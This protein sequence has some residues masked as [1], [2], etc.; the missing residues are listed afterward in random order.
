MRTGRFAAR[1]S[2]SRFTVPNFWADPKTGI[3]YQVQVEIPRP[4]VRNVDGIDT[5]HSAEDLGQIPLKRE[6]DQ[7][8]LVTFLKPLDAENSEFAPTRSAISLVKRRARP[9]TRLILVPPFSTHAEIAATP[10]AVGLNIAFGT[11]R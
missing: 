7:Q 8:V 3:A 4:V 10:A 5:I 1:T 9:A 6:G 2:S 11:R